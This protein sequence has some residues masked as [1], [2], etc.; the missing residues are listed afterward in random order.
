MQVCVSERIFR[1][2]VIQFQAHHRQA[3]LS[4]ARFSALAARLS[5]WR[6]ILVRLDVLG[7]DP[8]RY[9]GVSFGN[10]SGRLGPFPGQRGA[11]PFLITGSQT[12][13]KRCIDLDHYCVVTRYQASANTVD[14]YGPLLP[15]SESLTHGAIYDLG[16][17]IRFVFH[18]HAP[19]L[20]QRAR[21]LGVPMTA[22]EVS[23]GTPAMAREVAR[24]YRDAPLAQLGILAMGGHEDGVIT[25]GRSADEA[26]QVLVTFLARALESREGEPGRCRPSSALTPR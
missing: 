8:T 2:G 24:L 18:V 1:E 25:F 22:P 20:F 10:V 13:G 16:P 26:G 12:G 21:E 3:R 15:S 5:A 17:H 23:Y 6:D 11:R 19:A 14:S 4:S 9:D 7:E